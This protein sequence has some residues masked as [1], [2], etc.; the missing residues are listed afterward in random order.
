VNL[1]ANA[2]KTK[3]T[4]KRAKVISKVVK[5]NPS[6]ETTQ[7]GNKTGFKLWRKRT[8]SH[9]KRGIILKSKDKK[10]K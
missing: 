6:A 10:G 2:S 8:P 5:V 4:R 3:P 7:R 9:R 1:P